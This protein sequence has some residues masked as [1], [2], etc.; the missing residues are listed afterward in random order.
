MTLREK[1]GAS[2]RVGVWSGGWKKERTRRGEV[3]QIE[4]QVVLFF[5]GPQLKS[6]EIL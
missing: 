1:P 5:L 3:G 4:K 2:A 6:A